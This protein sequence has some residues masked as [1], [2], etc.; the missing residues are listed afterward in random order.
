MNSKL[1]T[2]GQTPTNGEFRDDGYRFDGS[3]WRR[4]GRNHH[5]DAD[6]LIFY[7]RKHRTLAGYL[8]QGGKIHR[9]KWA[10]NSPIAKILSEHTRNS[11]DTVEMGYVYLI[12]NP[13]YS[14]WVKCGKAVDVDNRLEGY[15]TSTPFR[16]YQEVYRVFT[17]N[18]H[19]AETLALTALSTVCEDR[20]GEWFKLDTEEAVSILENLI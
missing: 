16:N 2:T 9:I 19:S 13:S 18:R 3:S 10:S 17:N 15:Q 7:K 20:H 14:G 12:V 1:E 6:G 11:F 8:Q 5:Q 4:Y